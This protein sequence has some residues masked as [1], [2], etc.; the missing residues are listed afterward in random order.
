MHSY[1]S[2]A[3]LHLPPLQRDNCKPA[4][5]HTDKAKALAEHFY[6]KTAADLTNIIDTL[7]ANYTFYSS[8]ILIKQ[9][10]KANKVEKQ[11]CAISAQKALGDNYLLARFLLIYSPLLFKAII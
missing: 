5:M 2:A 7:F 6:S 11:L 10:I 4:T 9:F 1:A 8:A 3:S